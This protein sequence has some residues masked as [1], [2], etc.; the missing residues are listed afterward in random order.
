MTAQ[1]TVT[2]IGVGNMGGG[3]AANLLGRGWGV[4]VCDI[5]PVKVAD[6]TQIGAVALATPAQAAMDSQAF[7]ICV[8]DAAQTEAV[9]F[10][11]H[12]LASV[13]QPGHAVMLCPT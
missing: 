4:Q 8:V 12:G 2:L 13:L 9:L 3:M 10:G 5:D 6:M 7:I 11:R 1:K